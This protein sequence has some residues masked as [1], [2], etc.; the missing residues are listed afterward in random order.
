MQRKAGG[1]S[2]SLRCRCGGGQFRSW[3]VHPRG[4]LVAIDTPESRR[5]P[6]CRL[7]ESCPS[8]PGQ[9]PQGF[10]P[11]KAKPLRGGLRPALTAPAPCGVGSYTRNREGSG[12]VPRCCPGPSRYVTGYWL[13]I[14]SVPGLPP[15]DIRS[16]TSGLTAENVGGY[17]IWRSGLSCQTTSTAL[18]LPRQLPTPLRASSTRLTYPKKTSESSTK[19]SSR[20][21]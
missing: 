11:V 12:Q 17:T 16:Y 15:S 7:G 20:S 21:S 3:T 19:H 13:K 8:R 10:G 9:C 1:L 4:G 18:R 14:P 5:E 6:L 2:L